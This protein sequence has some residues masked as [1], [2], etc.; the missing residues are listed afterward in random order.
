MHPGADRC[1]VALSGE[2]DGLTGP[3]VA[4]LLDSA[5]NSGRRQVEV[6]MAQVSFLDL[7]GLRILLHSHRLAADRGVMLSVRNPQ[8]H[9]AWL[10]Q[11]TET[12]DRLLADLPAAGDA[13]LTGSALTGQQPSPPAM[14]MES[15]RLPRSSTDDASAT[16][17]RDAADERDRRADERDRR[18]DERDRRA[19]ERDHRADERDRRAD[20]RDHRADERDHRADE[21]DLLDAERGN[22]LKERTRRVHEHER[23]QDIRE[24]L[25]NIRE[26]D[27][28]RREHDR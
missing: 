19:D 18:A 22:L 26:H 2:L 27:L 13:T 24:D 4:E 14:T 21:R 17:R 20:E 5:T 16:D 3:A 6:D 10:L 12:T 9:I 25:A 28:D 7:A 1:T 8:P 15:A 23:W 11:T